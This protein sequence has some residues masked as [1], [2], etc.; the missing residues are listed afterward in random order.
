MS[1]LKVSFPT[2]RRPAFSFVCFFSLR[3]TMR[4]SSTWNANFQRR[5]PFLPCRLHLSDGFNDV[6]YAHKRT[7]GVRQR[8]QLSFHFIPPLPPPPPSSDRWRGLALRRRLIGDG[9]T[10]SLQRPRVCV[11][12]GNEDIVDV[13]VCDPSTRS[14]CRRPGSID[15][16]INDRIELGIDRR[17]E[18]ERW[19]WPK[20][21]KKRKETKTKRFYLRP[22]LWPFRPIRRPPSRRRNHRRGRPGWTR[23]S[24]W[25]TPTE[26][27]QKNKQTKQQTK[28]WNPFFFSPF[29]PF[30]EC[31]LCLPSFH[32]FCWVLLSFSKFYQV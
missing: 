24:R 18:T 22:R 29:Q 14:H 30:P 4:R 17:W 6:G 32:G 8:R 31:Y 20:K 2:F 26:F 11:S 9:L 10:T 13:D 23:P 7:K 27:Q 12:V 19:S 15:I 1:L 21:K 16:H 3:I 25:R 5:R 28:R